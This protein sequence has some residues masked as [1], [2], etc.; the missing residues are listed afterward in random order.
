MERIL[1]KI[2]DLITIQ[3]DTSDMS[4]S[5]LL[6]S[7]GIGQI[8]NL[9]LTIIRLFLRTGTYAAIHIWLKD[10][11]HIE[12]RGASVSHSSALKRMNFVGAW[13]RSFRPV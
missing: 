13:G 12:Q 3:K 4:V 2:Q 1:Q 10:K 9:D 7:R 6:Y 5:Q 11:D 8:L